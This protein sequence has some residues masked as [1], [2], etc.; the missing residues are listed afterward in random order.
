MTITGIAEAQTEFKP[1][2]LWVSGRFLPLRVSPVTDGTEVYIPPAALLPLGIS[3]VPNETSSIFT[4]KLDSRPDKIISAKFLKDRPMLPLSSV[5]LWLDAVVTVSSN[6]IATSD[7]V[8]SKPVTIPGNAEETPY[9]VF[10]LAKVSDVRIENGTLKVTTS[11]PVA[12]QLR[13][14]EQMNPPRAYL[15]CIG[16]NISENFQPTSLNPDDKRF[17]KLRTG[18]NSVNTARI[19]V[20]LPVGVRVASG[21]TRAKEKEILVNFSGTPKPLTPSPTIA[22]PA[23]NRPAQ[24]PPKTATKPQASVA[25]NQVP[26]P[27]KTV[28]T[29]NIDPLTGMPHKDRTIAKLP[30][31]GGVVKRVI[32]PLEVS[33]ININT[34]TQ[35]RLKFSL[36]TSYRGKAV[37]RYNIGTSQM[38]LDIP[39]SLLALPE[40]H[41]REQVV[42]HPMLKAV[43]LETYPSSTPEAEPVTRLTLD[44]ARTLGYTIT[45][46]DNSIELELRIPRNASGVL[47]DKLIVV[48][49]GHGGSAPGAMSGG[50]AEKNL[51]L[52]FSLRLRDILEGMGARVIMTRTDDRDIDL[53]ARSRIANSAGADFFISIHNDS[54]ANKIG[55]ASGTTIFYHKQDASSRAFAAAVL[56]AVAPISGLPN[57]GVVSDSV[58]YASGLGVLRYAR[59]PAILCEVAFINNPNDRRYLIDPD[60]QQRFSQAIAEGI[61][62]YVEGNS[63]PAIRDNEIF[64]P[65]STSPNIDDQR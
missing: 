49:P 27:K 62:A 24:Q 23:N 5:A 30:S 25:K 20:E 34:N 44:T 9:T 19:V 37:V 56:N 8:A 55:S 31:R 43:R 40:G 1:A 50:Y 54:T 26:A 16:A 41:P 32:L 58:L 4:L 13:M 52:Q 35:G 42:D 65:P 64:T 6:L 38:Y 46:T 18:Q 11:F 15:D 28:P 45:T 63:T 57:R 60:F 2:K 3:F 22:K 7:A 48:D 21:E 33:A 14:V 59:M 12:T 10:L 47:T 29:K 36:T 17:L 53:A 61:K 39:N 51:T